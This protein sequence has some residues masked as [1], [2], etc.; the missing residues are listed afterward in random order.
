MMIVIA[1]I[2]AAKMHQILVKATLNAP[3][4][5]FER[6]DTSVLVNRFSQDMTL[7]D[8]ALPAASFTVFMSMYISVQGNFD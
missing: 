7:V 6:T 8:L 3:L 4:A 1:P 2:S 5:F